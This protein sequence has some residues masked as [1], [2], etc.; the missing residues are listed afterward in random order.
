[1]GRAIL[2]KDGKSIP[3][4]KEDW[5]SEVVGST[6]NVGTYDENGNK[7]IKTYELTGETKSYADTIK[8]LPN[9]PV[10]VSVQALAQTFT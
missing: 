7:V 1:M 5:Y 3:T 9:T 6:L 4:E 2:D 10:N 8:E